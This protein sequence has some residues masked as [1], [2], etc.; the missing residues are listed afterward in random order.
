M[1]FFRL[2]LQVYWLEFESIVSEFTY[3]RLDI[4]VKILEFVQFPRLT[5]EKHVQLFEWEICYI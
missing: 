3:T 2:I 1:F 5:C 4:F